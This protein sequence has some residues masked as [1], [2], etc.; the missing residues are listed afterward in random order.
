MN[1]FN[2]IDISIKLSRRWFLGL[3][4][5]SACSAASTSKRQSLVVGAVSYEEGSKPLD[6]YDRFRRYLSEKM[7]NRVE[8]EP[9]LNEG[10]ALERIASQRWSLVFAPPGLTAIAMSQ[11]QYKP[12]FPLFGVQNLRSV[13]VVRNDSPIQSIA[14]VAGKSLAL[15]HPGSATG[16]YFPIFNLYGL[17]LS[18]LI[19]P[20]TPR[21]VLEAVSQGK[22]EVG[23]VSLAEFDSY[24]SQTTPFN[25]RILFNDPHQVPAG[26]VLISPNLDG[27]IQESIRKHLSE[28]SSVTAQEAGFV[29]NAPV[30]DYKYMISVV[31]RVRSIFPGDTR[32][33]VALLQQKPVRLFVQ[34]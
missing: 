21:A 15:G 1:E 11:H 13:L 20:P 23:A 32:E 22:A 2:K 10:M 6:Q 34:S 3:M 5:L 30:P 9:T 27:A 25:L 33:S 18:E 19:F 14:Q 7:Q 31:E 4:L 12:I 26:A 28:A 29:T 16:Y 17:T 8:L 24:K